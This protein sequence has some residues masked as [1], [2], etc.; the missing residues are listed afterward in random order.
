MIDGLWIYLPLLYFSTSDNVK[1]I[2]QWL[3]FLGARRAQR[4]HEEHE[5]LIKSA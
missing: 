3:R 2:N 1:G 4:E 5:E